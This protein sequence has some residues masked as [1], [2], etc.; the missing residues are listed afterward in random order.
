MNIAV[1]GGGISGMYAAYKLLKQGHKVHI[2]ESTDRLGGRILTGHVKDPITKNISG[3]ER[4][5]GRFNKSHKQLFALIHELG[6]M[7]LVKEIP[8]SK[9]FYMHESNSHDYNYLVK[10]LLFQ[11]LIKDI[12]RHN[13]K[14]LKSVTLK[15]Y[16]TRCYGPSISND[17]ISA[18]G[19]NSEFEIQ[20]AYT[21]L[22]LFQREFNDIIKYYYLDGGLSQIISSLHS[23]LVSLGCTIYLKT[24]VLDYNPVERKIMYEQRGRKEMKFDKVIFCLTRD[25]LAKF[26]TLVRHDN[27]LRQYLSSI[28][29]AP[30]TRIFAIFP[31]DK[32]GEVWFHDVPRT[33]TNLSVRYIIPINVNAGLIQVSYTDNAFAKFWS[34]QRLDVMRK[35]I[36][37]NL[38]RVF[39]HKRIPEPLW[40]ERT[41][42]KEGATYLKPNFTL[43]SNSPSS[44]YYICGEMMSPT[45][46][47]W[48]E[49]GLESVSKLFSLYNI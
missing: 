18:F 46:F 17:I 47:G 44:P 21:S 35:T 28:K 26:H 36:M 38:R 24:K 15:Q 32:S 8:N 1:I 4:G 37:S 48:I 40:M 29:S 13:S 27:L 6:L 45:H 5:A 9:R 49:G 16:L 22:K 14:Y 39:P 30:L 33:T 43:Y 3:Y 23:Q 20:N 2:F 10:H 25:T 11:K 42:W 41:Y 34:R 7:H 12:H 19:Y 31:R